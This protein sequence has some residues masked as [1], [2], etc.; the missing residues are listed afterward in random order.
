MNLPAS[1]QSHSIF[2]SSSLHYGPRLQVRFLAN[3]LVLVLRKTPRKRQSDHPPPP[4]LQR[5][6]CALLRENEASVQLGT[7]T[8]PGSFPWHCWWWGHPLG[9]L[10][11]QPYIQIW[12]T[13]SP[14]RVRF[15]RLAD[16]MGLDLR[17]LSFLPQQVVS[18]NHSVVPV[19]FC[20]VCFCHCFPL[21]RLHLP[22]SPFDFTLLLIYL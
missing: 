17:V 20:F 21:R 18:R 2:T 11:A 6:S 12:N 19:L 10:M 3:I 8:E 16:C 4:L 13:T 15:L 9:I 22:H 1:I 5:G 14:W 7:T